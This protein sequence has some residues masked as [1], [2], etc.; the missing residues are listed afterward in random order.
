MRQTAQTR[1]TDHRRIP[2]GLL[3]YGPLV[4][5]V[6]VQGVG[7]AVLMEVAHVITDQ[8][9]KMLFAQRDDMIEDLFATRSHSAFGNSVLPRCLE[10]RPLWFQTRRLQKR[11][12]VRVESRIAVQDRVSARGSLGKRFTQLLDDLVRGRV[13]SHVEVQNLAASVP[14]KDCLAVLTRTSRAALLGCWTGPR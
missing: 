12:H 8:P 13:P 4:R 6:L 9:A 3:L 14:F 1:T 2:Y 11:S 10:A 5:R 7:N